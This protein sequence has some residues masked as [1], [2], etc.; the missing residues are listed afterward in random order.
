MQLWHSRIHKDFSATSQPNSFSPLKM[1]FQLNLY[2][3]QSIDY[4]DCLCLVL[5]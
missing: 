3:S 4:S 1:K 2:N 5:K